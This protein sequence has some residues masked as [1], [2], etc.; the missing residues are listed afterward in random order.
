MSVEKNTQQQN[1]TQNKSAQ[2]TTIASNKSSVGIF[3]KITLVISIVAIGLSSYV[4]INSIS[5]IKNSNANLQAYTAFDKQLKAIKSTQDQQKSISDV[6]SAQNDALTQH[7]KALQSQLT[8]INNQM[9]LPA[10]DLYMQMSVINIQSAINYLILAKDVMVFAGDSQKASELV[11][12]AFDKIQASRVATVS[13]S[14]RQNIN[15][16]LEQYSS[17][18]D[19]IK[20]FITIEQQFAKLEYLTPENISTTAKSQKSQ[21]KYIKLLSAIVEI[22]DIPKNQTLVATTQTKEFVAD[23]LYRALISLQS[24]MYINNQDAIDKAKNNLVDIVKKYFV[25]N[26]DAKNLENAIQS[27]KAQNLDSLNTS[28]DKLISQLSKQQNQLLAQQSNLTET[29]ISTEGSKK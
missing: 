28:I 9:T 8:T 18:D 16:A 19:I 6:L 22:Q 25:Q 20:E 3:V 27:I 1:S 12:S 17:R 14:E 2:K 29:N 11:D 15:S 26:K 4:L 21:N 5:Q 23:N 7:I 10:K 24:A 13:A